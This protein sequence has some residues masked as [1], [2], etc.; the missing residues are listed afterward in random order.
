MQ[1]LQ[2][3]DAGNKD[4][5]SIAAEEEHDQQHREGVESRM[6]IAMGLHVLLQVSENVVEGS[7]I[8]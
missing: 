4:I 1:I 6:H 2:E 5:A 3:I 7:S 8:A